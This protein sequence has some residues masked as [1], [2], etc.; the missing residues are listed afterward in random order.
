MSNRRNNKTLAKITSMKFS[1]VQL[2]RM[3]ENHGKDWITF[4]GDN[5][6]PNF[7]IELYNKSAI[8]R[9]CINKKADAATR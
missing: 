2:P 5:L 9:T 6:Y 1:T 4:G 8:N 3:V 7:L